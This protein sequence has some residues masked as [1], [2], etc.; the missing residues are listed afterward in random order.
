MPAMRRMRLAASP[1]RSALMTGMPPAT[2]A[3]KASGTP[4]S[5]A[6]AASEAPCT[7]SSALLAVTTGLPA[8]MAA[9]ANARAGPSEPPISSTTTS[10]AGSAASATGSSY[11][12]RPDSDTPRSRVRSRA[13]TA[14]TAI[15]RPARA[16]TMSA[17]SRSSFSTPPPTVPRPA[18][19]TESGCVIGR[20]ASFR[21]LQFRLCLVGPRLHERPDIPH[22][23][24]QSMRIL[25]QRYAHEPLT[26]FA[27]PKARRYRH[28][29]ARQQE[30]GELHAAQPGKPR[31]Y[32]GPGEH[33][34]IGA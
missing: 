32:R 12:R 26:V 27:E 6:A 10:T 29:G 28:L 7:A 30:L 2:A 34:A 15:G 9:W 3:S 4:R 17:L 5:S 11:Q 24:A 1:S 14:V 23:L 33:R 31:R 22:R 16:V 8:A 21:A 19:A 13:D 20:Y 25:H 18:T